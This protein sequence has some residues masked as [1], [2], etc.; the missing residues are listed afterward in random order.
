MEPS[1][2][3]PPRDTWVLIGAGE[4]PVC[5]RQSDATALS[6]PKRWKP[7]VR[8]YKE[9]GSARGRGNERSDKGR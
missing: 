3:E 7:I 1:W 2:T 8:E 4:R 6:G 9:E 5:R